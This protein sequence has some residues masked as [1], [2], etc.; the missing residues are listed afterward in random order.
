MAFT[1][2][3]RT[4]VSFAAALPV[5]VSV[6]LLGAA[7]WR[8]CLALPTARL[9]TRSVAVTH[10]ARAWTSVQSARVHVHTHGYAH[11]PASARAHQPVGPA[12]ST[13]GDVRPHA[14]TR[15]S[16]AVNSLQKGSVDRH[17]AAA[18]SP[19]C[20]STSP[21][22]KGC[23]KLFVCV[24]GWLRDQRSQCGGGSQR[25]GRHGLGSTVSMLVWFPSSLR[26]NISTTIPPCQRAAVGAYSGPLPTQ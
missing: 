17:R 6:L 20:S 10:V 26:F 3:H 12:G 14:N 19:V 9:P 16:A 24:P 15:R 18:S 7:A 5:A 2:G 21:A 13:C 8:C 23:F 4:V 25:A 22:I 1:P 11:H